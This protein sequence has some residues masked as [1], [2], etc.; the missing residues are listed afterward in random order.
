MKP[1]AKVFVP[2]G[3]LPST[4]SAAAEAPAPVA[5]AALAMLSP[6]KALF[7]NDML[8]TWCKHPQCPQCDEP[9]NLQPKALRKAHECIRRP[10]ILQCGHLAC[11]ECVYNVHELQFTCRLCNMATPMNPKWYVSG[12]NIALMCLIWFCF[13]SVT[14]AVPW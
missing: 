9:F 10:L 2:S 4:A 7:S 6:Q 5:A 1:T 14:F 13:L 8:V 3:A 11:K 12:L